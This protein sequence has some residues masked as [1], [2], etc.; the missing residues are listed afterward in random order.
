MGHQGERA[1]LESC[2]NKIEEA[3]W[4]GLCI[5]N[6][7]PGGEGGGAK[8]HTGGRLGLRHPPPHSAATFNVGRGQEAVREAPDP[9]PLPGGRVGRP[10]QCKAGEPGRPGPSH[11]A[12]TSTTEL[13]WEVIRVEA[14]FAN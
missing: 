3:C 14:T 11:T 4:G 10:R 9:R 6:G 5:E 13:A 1:G 12:P 7:H 2:S 8:R